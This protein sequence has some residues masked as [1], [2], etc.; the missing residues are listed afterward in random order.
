M[1][2]DEMNKEQLVTELARLRQRI[3]ALEHVEREHQQVREALQERVKELH[4]LYGISK[5]VEKHEH[6]LTE[7]LQ[8]TVDLI[9]HRLAVSGNYLR[10]NRF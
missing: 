6:A 5:R 3:A 4:C 7:I 2:D 1:K 9:A 8:G 10:T